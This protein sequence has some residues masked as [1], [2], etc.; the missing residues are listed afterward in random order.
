MKNYQYEN[1]QILQ[2]FSAIYCSFLWKMKICWQE[3]G[4]RLGLPSWQKTDA[5]YSGLNSCEQIS[6][7]IQASLVIALFN[8]PTKLEYCI[9]KSPTYIHTHAGI[10][11][12]VWQNHL[13]DMDVSATQVTHLW[14]MSRKK[15]E[16]DYGKSESNKKP[17]SNFLVGNNSCCRHMYANNIGFENIIWEKKKAYFE[18][19]FWSD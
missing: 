7:D 16:T 15:P 3:D 19:L 9:V 8:M 12:L 17:S 5:T 10:L 18:K 6:A 14:E 11:S 13:S 2:L 1:N 4:V